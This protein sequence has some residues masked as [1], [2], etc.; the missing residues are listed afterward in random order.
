MP[1][2]VTPPRPRPALRIGVTGHRLNRLL[3]PGVDLDALRAQVR[4]A[5]STVRAAVEQAASDYDQVYAGPPQ[6][7]LISPLAEG[8]DQLVASEALELGYALH[9][10]LPCLP[11]IYTAA[12]QRLTRRKIRARDFSG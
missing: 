10:P 7:R 2:V 5:L 6:L 9:V 4:T 12:F 1:P 3:E 8:A 11:E